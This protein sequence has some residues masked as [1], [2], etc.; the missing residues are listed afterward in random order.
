LEYKDEAGRKLTDKEAYRQ[1]SYKFH[2]RAPTKTVR[3]KRLKR[4]LREAAIAKGSAQAGGPTGVG[5][6]LAGMRRVQEVTGSAHV[7]LGKK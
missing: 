5:G 6:S 1:L 3:D 4:T 7:T 2:G